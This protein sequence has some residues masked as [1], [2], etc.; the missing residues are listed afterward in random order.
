[1]DELSRLAGGGDEVVPAAGDV[2]V[3][4]EAEDAVGEGVA[5]V[6]IVEEPAVEMLVAERGLDGV[7]IHGGDFIWL[8]GCVLC[9]NT[10]PHLKS[11]VWCSS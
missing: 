1:M 6:M 8:G 10:K 7:E 2:G 4:V 9:R 11:G 5:V 3:V